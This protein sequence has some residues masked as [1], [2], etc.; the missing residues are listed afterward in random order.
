MHPKSERAH[1]ETSD[2]I[3][4]LAPCL[5]S[6]QC[7]MTFNNGKLMELGTYVTRV[8]N[9]RGKLETLIIRVNEHGYTL[10]KGYKLIEFK[11]KV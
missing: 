4:T 8:I 7:M 1:E 11:N 3:T 5:L 2:Y 9:R 10:P 6:T